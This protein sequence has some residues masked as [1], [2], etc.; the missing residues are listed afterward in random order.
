MY[1][2]CSDYYDSMYVLFLK[3]RF[4]SLRTLISMAILFLQRAILKVCG[5]EGVGSGV[6]A[7]IVNGAKIFPFLPII[8][9]RWLLVFEDHLFC[10]NRRTKTKISSNSPIIRSIF[11]AIIILKWK[12]EKFEHC[13]CNL[14][15]IFHIFCHW[16]FISDKQS[17]E[18]TC[19]RYK[20]SRTKV[21]LFFFNR[22]DT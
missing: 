5:A 19:C 2:A 21:F 1:I 16:N 6:V 14:L 12:I 22:G 10:T 9:N 17:I 3:W 4:I 7:G 18:Q 20:C 11:A 15:W 13:S 8:S